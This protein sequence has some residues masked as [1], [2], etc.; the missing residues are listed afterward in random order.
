MDIALWIGQ[1]FL[2]LA[3]LGSAVTHAVLWERTSAD[4]RMAWVKD[5]GRTRAYGIGILETAGAIGVIAP[6]VTGIQSWL[7]PVAATGLFLLMVSAIVFHLIRREYP[8]IV[9]NVILGAVALFVAYGRFV[10]VPL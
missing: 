9:L 2:T 8:N 6:A 7:V 10:L 5:I 1:G 4:P 3:F